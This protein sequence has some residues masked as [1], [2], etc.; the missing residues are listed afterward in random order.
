MKHQ[1][2]F[3]AA[4]AAA[5]GFSGSAYA[6]NGDAKVDISQ[7]NP[8]VAYPAAAQRNNEQGTVRMLVKVSDLGE[9]MRIRVV[10]S[11]GY[12][13]LDTA[14]AEGVM[15]WH[16]IPSTYGSDWADVQVVYQEPA[17]TPAS[18]IATAAP[19]NH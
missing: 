5:L 10:K 15:R 19:A 1:C 11:S 9:P 6:A 17:M 16:Y 2:L 7:P 12:D 14:A 18:A 8:P 4:I 3:A 13:D